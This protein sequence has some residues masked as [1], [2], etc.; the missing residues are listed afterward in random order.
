VPDEGRQL[1]QG[2][3]SQD[4]LLHCGLAEQ[5]HGQGGEPL[6]FTSEDELPT[7]P[8]LQQPNA[9]SLQASHAP[10]HRKFVLWKLSDCVMTQLGSTAAWCLPLGAFAA[11]PASCQE[12]AQQARGQTP[13][14]RT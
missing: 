5:L 1:C 2:I 10:P 13:H 7:K 9:C 4:Q 3:P 14:R 8:S 11:S 6:A 12:W